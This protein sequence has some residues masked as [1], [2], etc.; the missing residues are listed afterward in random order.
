[1][2]KLILI[3]LFSIAISGCRNKT[4]C[5]NFKMKCEFS[6]SLSMPCMVEITKNVNVGQLKM[7]GYYYDYNDSL[8]V[9]VNKTA[10]LDSLKICNFLSEI[11]EVDIFNMKK[12]EKEWL[13]GVTVNIDVRCDSR[14]NI[15]SYNSPVKKDD[16]KEYK[17]SIAILNLIKENLKDDKSQ[18]IVLILEQYFN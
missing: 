11:E 14:K 2:K 13:D 7:E 10:N 3:F 9:K 15:F 8:M 18:N 17:L 5:D 1:M 6:P 16:P 4:H 12:K